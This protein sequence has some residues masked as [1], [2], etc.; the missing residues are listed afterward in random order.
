MH[1]YSHRTSI[2]GFPLIP[3]LRM[4]LRP[5]LGMGLDSYK[6]SISCIFEPSV[7]QV[8]NEWL[9]VLP[10]QVL[11]FKNYIILKLSIHLPSTI[12]L[13]LVGGFNPFQKN[14]S[15][16]RASSQFSGWKSKKNVWNCQLEMFS[17]KSPKVPQ[18]LSSGLAEI[19]PS[20]GQACKILV[21]FFF[22]KPDS[23]GPLH[24][25]LFWK[26]WFQHVFGF[27]EPVTPLM[28]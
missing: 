9:E 8:R 17:F 25:V 14:I 2:P 20:F 7:P 22:W 21:T 19:L 23:P 12:R 24:R 13:D 10:V 4:G 15:Q 28:I 1:K 27:L 6:M 11:G 5:F 16:I 3:I 26:S 18:R